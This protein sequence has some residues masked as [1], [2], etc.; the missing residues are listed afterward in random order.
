L[1]VDRQE[2]DMIIEKITKYV[3]ASSPSR[4]SSNTF[5]R[6]VPMSVPRVRWLERDGSFKPAGKP[7]P[8]N[9]DLGKVKRKKRPC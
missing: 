9:I 6:M 2:I 5:S 4:S 1:V 8:V 7:E 3:V